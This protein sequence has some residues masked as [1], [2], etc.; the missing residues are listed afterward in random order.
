MLTEFLA[1]VAF[2]ERV[3]RLKQRVVGIQM[4]ED[5]ADFCQVFR[6]FCDFEADMREAYQQT[7]RVFRG[8]APA[9][10]GP[11]TKDLC[12]VTGLADILIW[13]K[14]LCPRDR[15]VQ[16]PLLFCG[17]VALVD[18]PILADLNRCGWLEAPATC[19]HHFSARCA[20]S[21]AAC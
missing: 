13:L 3:R 11:F 6:F 21:A 15:E 20:G 4:A 2:P 19:P 16:I 8:S 1:G 9:G 10:C 5:G 7:A 18:V 14:D 12:Y 17:K